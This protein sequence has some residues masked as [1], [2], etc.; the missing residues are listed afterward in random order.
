M[1]NSYLALI[2]AASISLSSAAF[3]TDTAGSITGSTVP[4]G[5]CDVAECEAFLANVAQANAAGS[6]TG[7]TVPSGFCED[8]AA[9]E[10]FLARS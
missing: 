9:C 8:V 6:I 7:T 5:L 1:K 3:A 2:F 4:S 10:A